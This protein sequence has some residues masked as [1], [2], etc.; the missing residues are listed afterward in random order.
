MTGTA[1]AAALGTT[2][3]ATPEYFGLADEWVAT[4]DGEVTHYH[5]AGSG[6]PVVLLHGSG[7]GVSAAANWWHNIPVLAE[8]FDVIA[9]DIAGYGATIDAPDAAYGI[10]EWGAHVLRLLDALGLEQVWL[11]GNSL[12]GWIALQLALDHPERLLGVVSMGTGGAPRNAALMAHGDPDLSHDGLRAA[13][14]RFVTDTSIVH[15]DYVAARVEVGR[16]EHAS[17]RLARIFEA[18]ERDRDELPLRAEDLG[19]LTLP[20][21]LV[22]GMQDHIIPP[23]RTWSL[24]QAIPHADSLLLG[25]CGHWSQVERAEEF[26]AA[27]H[28]FIRSHTAS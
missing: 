2:D 12:G 5:R 4:G 28:R 7:T 21:L 16:H 22:H 8:H 15:D 20:V 18:R 14:E 24:A 6:V 13:F 26:N 10:R 27:V 23:A 17:G 11:V 9:P 1:R 19:G 25:R 3:Y